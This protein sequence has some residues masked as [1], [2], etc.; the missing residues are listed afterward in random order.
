MSTR[1]TSAT[2]TTSARRTSLRVSSSLGILC[3]SGDSGWCSGDVVD[4]LSSVGPVARHMSAC[5]HFEPF[6]AGSHGRVGSRH[7]SDEFILEKLDVLRFLRVIGYH[8]LYIYVIHLMVTSFTRTFF[9][10]FL[11]ITYVPVIL[12]ASIILGVL[13]PIVFYNL[14]MKINGWWLF[15]SRPPKAVGVHAVKSRPMNVPV[16]FKKEKK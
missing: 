10:R 1:T 8:S 13:I 4:T 16:I 2:T 14:T 12:V 6:P 3:V 11:D 9:V 15:S 7:A 5:A